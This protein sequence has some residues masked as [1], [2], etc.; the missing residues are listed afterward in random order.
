MK[1]NDLTWG[2]MEAVVNKLGGMDGVKKFLSGA[3]IVVEAAVE[4]ILEFVGIVA[5]DATNKFIAGEHFVIDT[6]ASAKVKIGFI[7]E[8]FERWFLDKTEERN[9][10]VGLRY[11][12]LKKNSLDKLI[13][14]ELGN[15]V[16]TT[17]SQIWEL[18]KLQPWREDGVLL[19]N[20][21]ANIFYVRDA[22]GVLRA[23]NVRWYGNDGVWYVYAHSVEY[24]GRWNAGDRIFSRNS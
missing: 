18:L 20:G 5:V 9:I 12:Q 23:V 13:M 19:T 8:S 22:R 24:P 17:L 1:Y 3:L 14:D 10:Y 21:Y 6:S 4:K 7:G 2:Q 15:T 16:E 11:H